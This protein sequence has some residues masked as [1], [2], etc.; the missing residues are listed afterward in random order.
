[1]GER[2]S[3]FGGFDGFGLKAAAIVAMTCNHVANVFAGQLPPALLFPL[4]AVGGLTF[5]IMAFLLVEGYRHTSNVGMYA[6]RLAI[7]ACVA[8]VPYSLLWGA[9]PNVLFTLLM[10]LGALWLH[11]KMGRNPLFLLVLMGAALLTLPFDWG[12]IGVL[13]VSLFQV[14]RSDGEGKAADGVARP[15]AKF[16]AVRGI[17]AAMLVPYLAIGLPALLELPGALEGGATAAPVTAAA[18]PSVPFDAE[19]GT[20]GASTTAAPAAQAGAANDA[21]PSAIPFAK[22]SITSDDSL[23]DQAADFAAHTAENMVPFSL[24]GLI[25]GDAS[26]HTA[27]TIAQAGHLAEVWGNIGYAFVGFTLAIVV[28]GCYNGQ[29]GRSMKWFFY[30][31]YPAHL[32]IIWLVRTFLLPA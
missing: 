21:S 5:P 23:G 14:V 25:T 15:S 6:L 28:L 16:A 17:A 22:A 9:V 18:Q 13:L 2:K 31:Y 12:C 11:D 30:G 7:F 20:A 10:G 32:L 4:F 3:A 8:Q 24:D 27:N 26:P 29:R 1:M 19:D